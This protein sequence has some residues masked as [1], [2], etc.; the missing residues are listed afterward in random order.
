MKD[1]RPEQR[2]N[3]GQLHHSKT[4][5]S[6]SGDSLLNS[7]SFLAACSDNLTV[8]WYQRDSGLF[9]GA[10]EISEIS[11][12]LQLDNVL[13]GSVRK[14][15]NRVRITAQLINGNSDKHL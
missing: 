3:N 7:N 5:R 6:Y 8:H 13:E 14:A 1:L 2:M 11:R 10:P 9:H 15:G 4:D 12:A